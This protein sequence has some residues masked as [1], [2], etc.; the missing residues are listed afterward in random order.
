MKSI[1]VLIIN[2]TD[3]HGGAGR[4]AHRIHKGLLKNDLLSKMLVQKKY[5]DDF[6]V[7][8]VDTKYRKYL[9]YPV[10][11]II[12]HIPL[13]FYRKR[14]KVTWSLNWF[15]SRRIKMI[16]KLDS[17]IINLHWINNGFIRLQDL[18]KIR[19]PI[20]WTLHDM[21]AFTG[22]CHYTEHCEK[23]EKKCYACHI[24]GTK[25][26]RDLSNNRFKVKKKI[27]DKLNITIV[28]PSRWLADCARKSE[29]LKNKNIKV[30]PNGIDLR[31]FRP[32][33]T[34]QAREILDVPKDKKLILFSALYAT[35]DLRKGFQ[36]LFSALKELANK[37]S[38]ELLVL[39]AGEPETKKKIRFGIKTHYL[40]KLNDDYS[41]ILAYN[42]ADV[43]VVP[44]V[45]DNLPNTIKEALA[46][47][48]PCVGFDIGG[49]PDMIEHKYN[50][51]ISK[52]FIEKD[53]AN[54]IDW[55][56]GQN[57][58]LIRKRAR[59]KAEDMLDIDKTAL[60][61]SQLYKDILN[62]KVK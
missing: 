3:I 4:A 9:P 35:S 21:W 29:L 39:G 28:T 46:C 7:E 40:G 5:S 44:S 15:R 56:L 6:T 52:A 34:K 42:A 61:Y 60:K 25:K 43:L 53:L 16:N 20:V 32:L 58:N 31:K 26:K 30:I 49:I 41:L 24:L 62:Y 55:V 48:T 2:A 12:D 23:Y 47:G 36:Y 14:K 45:Q 13:L 10:P 59:K 38:Y 19:K 17:D 57:K 54:G 27:Y 1:K 18:K 51:Y 8:E 33:D 11:L 37:N 22:G 50:G